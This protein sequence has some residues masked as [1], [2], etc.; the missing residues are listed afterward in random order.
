V[1]L[2][3]DYSLALQ[4][5]FSGETKGKDRQAGA[6]LD[7]TGVTNLF[8]GPRV[9]LTWGTSLAAEAGV[10]LPILQHET[11]LQI[12]ADHR[13]RAALVWRF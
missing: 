12:V 10:E 5:A 7:D 3:H 6:R 8:V 1:L 13:L 4:A 9:L 11:A 2:G